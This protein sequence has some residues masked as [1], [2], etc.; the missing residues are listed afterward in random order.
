MTD[1]LPIGHVFEGRQVR[2]VG[3]VEN[4]EWI[5]ADICNILDL[6]TSLAVNGRPDREGSGLDSDEKGTAVVSTLGGAQEMLTVKEAGLYRLIFKCRKP[7]A[8]RFQRWIAHDVLP[9]I[10]RTGSYSLPATQ[11]QTQHLLPSK[12]DVEFMVRRCLGAGVSRT[13]ALSASYR[14]LRQPQ[15]LLKRSCRQL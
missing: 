10:R 11:P 7:I 5:A 2:F 14:N 1:I 4:P 3:T 8:K 13:I 15:A 6:D 9:S 12:D